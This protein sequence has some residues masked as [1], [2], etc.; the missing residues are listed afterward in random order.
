MPSLPAGYM[1]KEGKELSKGS[2]FWR[3]I[4]EEA[5]KPRGRRRVVNIYKLD[6][7]TREGD[8]VFVPGKILSVGKLNHPIVVS[9][10]MLSKSAYKKIVDA[11]G[12]VLTLEEFMRTY[13]DGKNVKI[14]G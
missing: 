4:L 7:H 1:V 3:A 9:A 6:R 13:P 10:F 12:K 8:V 5:M 2:R 11:G 14:I